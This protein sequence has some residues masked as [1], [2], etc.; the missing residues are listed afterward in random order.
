LNR[1]IFYNGTR[2]RSGWR[3]LGGLLLMPVFLVAGVVLT[4]LA[5]AIL[6][7]KLSPLGNLYVLVG[8]QVTAALGAIWIMIKG[9]G[10]WARWFVPMRWRD[11]FWG[12][13]IAGLV[14]GL[15]FGMLVARHYLQVTGMASFP[16]QY[17]PLLLVVAVYEEILFRGFI[18]QTAAGR[19]GSQTRPYMGVV[20]SALAFGLAHANNPS[21]GWAPFLGITLAGLAFGLTYVKYG[22]LWLLIGLH[23]GWD[24][25][26]GL[27]FGFPTSGL[28]FPAMLTLKITGPALWTGGAFGPEA[29]LILLPGLALGAVLVWLYTR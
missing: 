7:V 8:L 9:Q 2:L 19:G 24:F 18:L 22:S 1:A 29:G 14:M 4:A 15:M 13:V 3:L 16:W 21:R 27:V 12:W 28:A 11:M 25:F 10:M 26:E 5:L 20:V 17:V 23:F 6:H